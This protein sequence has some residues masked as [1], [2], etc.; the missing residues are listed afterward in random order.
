MA[1]IEVDMVANI[2]IYANI[3]KLFR[4]EAYLACASSKLY[5]FIHVYHIFKIIKIGIYKGRF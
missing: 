5:E 2:N 3:D 4:P 1:D